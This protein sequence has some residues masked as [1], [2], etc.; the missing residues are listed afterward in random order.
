[1]ATKQI[2]GIA[3][4]KANG[5]LFPS[6]PGA[7][8]QIGGTTRT[9]V[10]GHEVYGYSEQV[11]PA[12]VQCVMAARNDLSVREINDMVDVQIRFEC[13]SGQVYVVEGA[14]NS[15]PP[16]ITDNGQGVQCQFEGPPA[17]EELPG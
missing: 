5:K 9:S 4:I 11:T 10:V 2:F 15:S 8:I 16:T 17:R 6:M 13:D 3:K 14:W 7:N 1:M 12:M